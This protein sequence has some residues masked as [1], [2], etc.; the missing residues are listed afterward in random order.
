MVVVT[1]EISKRLPRALGEAVVRILGPSASGR[2]I[3]PVRR[4]RS[5][6]RPPPNRGA[7]RRGWMRRVTLRCGGQ[8]RLGRAKVAQSRNPIQRSH[9]KRTTRP[10]SAIRH[11]AGRML[12]ARNQSPQGSRSS[13][14]IR[15]CAANTC[16]G[17]GASQSQAH[18]NVSACLATPRRAK[19][20][21][22]WLTHKGLKSHLQRFSC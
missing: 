19:R 6:S 21:S 2:S 5:T 10:Q 4:R 7:S 3:S 17:E 12:D 9:S 22:E 15:L 14:T 18:A 13:V 8:F 20:W 1:H 16:P 11:I